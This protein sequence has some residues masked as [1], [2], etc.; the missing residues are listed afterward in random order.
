MLCDLDLL[1]SLPPAELV[2]G[3]GEVIKCGFIADPEI[4]R[5]VEADPGGGPRPGV[6]GSCARSSSARSR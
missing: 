5:V 3:L 1:D 4:L 6:A 2:S